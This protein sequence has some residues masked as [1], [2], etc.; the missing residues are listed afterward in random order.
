MSYSQVF[1][2]SSAAG[3]AAHGLRG[4][5]QARCCVNARLYFVLE[6][7]AGPQYRHQAATPSRREDVPKLL[8]A[9]FQCWCSGGKDT[10]AQVGLRGFVGSISSLLAKTR[11]LHR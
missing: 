6:H 3:A 2:A 1:N 9:Q 10:E 8:D 11:D 5:L 7:G 4:S